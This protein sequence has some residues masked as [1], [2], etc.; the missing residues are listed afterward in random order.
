MGT[1][2]YHPNDNDP[3]M[4]EA[5]D[6]QSYANLAKDWAIKMDGPVQG[7]SY[8][9]QWNATLSAQS[10]GE[11]AASAYQAQ[12]FKSLSAEYANAP[13]DIYVTGTSD[14]SSYHWSLKSQAY[15]NSAQASAQGSEQWA[16]IAQQAATGNAFREISDT[17]YTITEGDNGYTL[18]FTASVP[19]TITV[20]G[21][22]ALSMGANISGRAV[23]A[24]I[25][26][27]HFVD[28]GESAIH[29]PNNYTLSMGQYASVDFLRK[30][31]N[32]WH[33]SG[34]LTEYVAI[35]SL[36][37]ESE[38]AGTPGGRIQG[39]AV[40][41]GNNFFLFGGRNNNGT[42]NDIWK[43][44]PSDDSWTQLMSGATNRR[45]FSM[46]VDPNSS[47]I[48]IYG[49]I[50][51]WGMRLGDFW[52]YDIDGDSWVSLTAPGVNPRH[53]SCLECVNSKIYLFGGW[54]GAT[55]NNDVWEYDITAGSW[56]QKSS[57]GPSVGI[58]SSTVVG[59]D[60]YLHGGYSS[61]YISTLWRYDVVA[62]SWLQMSDSPI[63]VYSHALNTYNG[64]IYSI[65]GSSEDVTINS[66]FEFDP[67]ENNWTQL[68]DMP[69]VRR[70]HQSAEV[71]GK[72]FIYGG[73]LDSGDWSGDFWLYDV[74]AEL[75][76]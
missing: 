3:Q 73:I 55:E 12:Q 20:P 67:V 19:V 16:Q 10:A 53:S 14:Y 37:H 46:T 28:D 33:L 76:S 59:T 29:S 23:Q 32:T 61:G 35:W 51:G 31:A 56:T 17:T 65:G 44:D 69:L 45:S 8:S 63:G 6:A 74:A 2:F 57:G 5:Q 62:D 71:G 60:I 26:E 54:D 24:G 40:S 41:V 42:Y 22:T 75:G 13:E 66:V 11:S 1:G 34:D 72:I 27:L 49:G 25:G 30:D 9:S 18:W 52:V 15:S 36:I 7:E 38:A 39:G 58:R 50:D 68:G 70:V 47:K 43:F 4:V 21:E 48:Y 64:K